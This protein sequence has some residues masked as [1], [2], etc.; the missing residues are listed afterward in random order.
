MITGSGVSA[1][2]GVPTFREAQTGL[3]AQYDPLELATP[4]AFLSNP[5]L[6]WEWYA[7]RRELVCNVRPNS[8]HTALAEIERRKPGLTLITQNVDGLHQRAGSRNVVEFH[9]NVHR[10]RCHECRALVDAS[11]GAPPPPCPGCGGPVR[12]DVV[13]FGEAIAPQA[14]QAAE[15]ALA[16]CQV[17]LSVGTSAQVYPAAAF[18]QRA[19]QRD[20]TVVEVNTETTPLTAHA[21]YALKGSATMW[22]PR[23]A[24][25]VR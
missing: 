2:S 4:E 14:L 25:V 11:P 24:E 7:W 19:L 6:V 22:L 17:L 1:E 12:P 15:L 21:D 20:I 3:W 9:G 10:N 23:I 13:W 8:A 16:C 5:T 18:A